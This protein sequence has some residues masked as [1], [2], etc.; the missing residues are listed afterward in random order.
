MSASL[1]IIKET[2]VNQSELKS[3]M[4]NTFIPF[5]FFRLK[6]SGFLQPPKHTNHTMSYRKIVKQNFSALF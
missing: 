4:R 6:K 1:N 3:K 5:L 2:W